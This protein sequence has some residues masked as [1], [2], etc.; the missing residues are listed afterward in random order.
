MELLQGVED[1]DAPAPA[2]QAAEPQEAEQHVSQAGSGSAAGAVEP[3]RLLPCSLKLQ[4]P[5]YA[6][7]AVNH[8]DRKLYTTR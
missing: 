8:K 7:L 2:A 4:P 1:Q 3:Q 6:C 5:V